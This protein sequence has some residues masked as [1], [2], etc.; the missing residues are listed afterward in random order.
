MKMCVSKSNWSAS[1]IPPK[2]SMYIKKVS[3][4]SFTVIAAESSFLAVGFSDFVVVSSSVVVGSS[5]VIESLVAV[6]SCVG[7]D[8]FVV[9]GSTVVACSSAV[10]SSSVVSRRSV[11]SVEP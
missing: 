2:I 7:Y 1:F 8:F 9:V 3:P 5:V 4:K 11:G 6:N 10:A